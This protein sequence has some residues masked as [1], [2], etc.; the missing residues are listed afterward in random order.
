[1]GQ[2]VGTDEVPAE[3]TK[4]GPGM[5]SQTGS[6]SSPVPGVSPAPLPHA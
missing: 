6:H 1:M 5:A 2:G 3:D 4:E